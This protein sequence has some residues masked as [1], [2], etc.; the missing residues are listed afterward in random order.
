[1]KFRSWSLQPRASTSLTSGGCTARRTCTR[2]LCKRP[3]GRAAGELAGKMGYTPMWWSF[4]VKQCHT[5]IQRAGDMLGIC[6]ENNWITL[7][8]GGWPTPLKNMSQLGWLF[9]IY[10]KIQNIP[11]HQP[12]LN[13]WLSIVSHPHVKQCPVV[14]VHLFH[15]S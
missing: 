11:N 15:R 1:M 9:P 4:R 10:G 3:P 7:L 12:A 6:L 13:N 2:E 14:F 5:N 8:V